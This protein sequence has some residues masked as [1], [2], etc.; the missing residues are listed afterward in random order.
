MEICFGG[1]GLKDFE[2]V[3]KIQRKY[4]RVIKGVNNR[5]PLRYMVGEFKILTVTSL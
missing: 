2:T 4:L 5:V 3:F 1:G